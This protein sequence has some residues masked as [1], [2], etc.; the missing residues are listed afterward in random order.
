MSS[1]Y[2]SSSSTYSHG[3][4]DNDIELQADQSSE[5][6]RFRRSQKS[7]E[8]KRKKQ[9]RL[10]RKRRKD[11]E[12][13]KRRQRSLRSPWRERQR[14]RERK[15]RRNKWCCH[16]FGI[17]MIVIACVGLITSIVF[18]AI[19]DQKNRE[20]EKVKDCKYM[21]AVLL[22][23][24]INGQMHYLFRGRI[25]G[26]F[27]D[28]TPMILNLFEEWESDISLPENR[29]TIDKAGEQGYLDEFRDDLLIYRGQL[30]GFDSITW[31]RVDQ[32]DHTNFRICWDPNPHTGHGAECSEDTLEWRI[33]YF[34]I[35]L[36]CAAYMV[37]YG[38]TVII[39]IRE[40]SEDA[41]SICGFGCGVSTIV[42]VF[43][44]II[45]GFAA[46]M[47]FLVGLPERYEHDHD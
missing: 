33:G 19:E 3:E 14:E 2:S 41:L 47:T 1:T 37:T 45:I 25:N 16:I 12:R 5:S 20:R 6:W 18:L 15:E 13:R 8:R 31:C 4:E 26:T 29:F 34:L 21:D 39:A 30:H 40:D 43:T 23:K 38:I 22:N 27:P 32:S 24:T 11:R 7:Q 9:Q 36:T 28:G 42:L 10:K 44:I 17:A 35:T 46:C